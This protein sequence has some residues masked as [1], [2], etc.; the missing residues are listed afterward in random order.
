MELSPVAITGAGI[1]LA[2][3][4]ALTYID[5]DHDDGDD[6]PEQFMRRTASILPSTLLSP[7]LTS[8]NVSQ[9]YHMQN[10]AC[11]GTDTLAAIDL[12][13]QRLSDRQSA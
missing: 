10:K 12:D 5:I 9:Q 4:I 6:E 2:S 7:S 3:F 13:F 8:L 1:I 11:S